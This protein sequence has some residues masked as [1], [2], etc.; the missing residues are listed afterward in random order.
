MSD[1]QAIQKKYFTDPI[2][3]NPAGHEVL[4]DVLI[5]YMQAQ[6]CA[7]WSG[8]TGHAGGDGTGAL[9]ALAADSVNVRQPSDARGLFGGAGIRK[10]GAADEG[11]ADEGEGAGEDAPLRG[12]GA[13]GVGGTTDEN[14]GVS[15]L[16]AH[17]R[18]PATRIST[19]PAD[20]DARGLKEVRPYC[21]TAN[22][23][24]NPLPESMFV[25]SGWTAVHPGVGGTQDLYVGGH[26]WEATMPGSKFRIPV[27]LGAGDVGLF[28]LREP[29][30][31]VKDGSFVDCW[32][33]DNTAGKKRVGNAAE[34]GDKEPT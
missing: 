32:V 3:A 4:A 24:V 10:G 17:L 23:L 26:Y 14:D 33:D 30:K 7:V 11:A 16:A 5:S 2:L 18:V 9:S 1:A 6:V 8:A 34:V 28:Y 25:G 12:Q 31:D 15:G 27:V 21:A 22:D 13:G 20:I 29:S 19:R